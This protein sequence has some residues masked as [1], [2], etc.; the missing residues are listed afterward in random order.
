MLQLVR[1]TGLQR[2]NLEAEHPCGGF[3]LGPQYLA[4]WTVGVM[5]HPDPREGWDRLLKQLQPLLSEFQSME[6]ASAAFASSS[7]LEPDEAATVFSEI[8]D[9]SVPLNDLNRGLPR[10]Q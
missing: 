10:S 4:I 1:P 8:L 7:D 9:A 5:E 3:R 6:L 2:L